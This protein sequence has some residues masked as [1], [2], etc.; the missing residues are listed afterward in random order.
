MTPIASIIRWQNNEEIESYGVAILTLAN[1][2]D[3]N[4]LQDIAGKIVSFPTTRAS[5]TS[6]KVTYAMQL[7]ADVYA[8]MSM[9]IVALHSHLTSC[10]A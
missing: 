9:C 4:A 3:I 10:T 8:I 2:T 5:V 1:R 7:Y 6:A